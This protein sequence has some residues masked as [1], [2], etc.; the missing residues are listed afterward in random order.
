MTPSSRVSCAGKRRWLVGAGR[1]RLE[2]WLFF[3]R[4]E[5]VCPRDYILCYSTYVIYNCQQVGWRR[6]RMVLDRDLRKSR[7][8]IQ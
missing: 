6:R 4:C 2:D 7:R 3:N 8:L 5:S 1:R